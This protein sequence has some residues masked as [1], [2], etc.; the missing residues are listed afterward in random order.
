MTH[1][2]IIDDDAAACRS[3]ERH[4]SAARY[5]ITTARQDTDALA[6]ARISHPD[7]IIIDADL[8]DNRARDICKTLKRLERTREIPI[9][10]LSASRSL[11]VAEELFHAGASEYLSKPYTNDALER[12]VQL[13]LQSGDPGASG[14]LDIPA[15]LHEAFSSIAEQAA[16]LGDMAEV[17]HGITPRHRRFRRQAPLGYDWK[18]ILSASQVKRFVLNPPEVFYRFD[19]TGLLR[20][21]LPEEY[22]QPEK[23]VLCRTAP[24][25]V[26]AVDSSQH[27]VANDLYSIVPAKGLGC[28][29]LACLLNS[30]L[31]DF[32][33]NRI[34]PIQ[35]TPAGT[36]L[37]TVDI[38]AI[39]V[40]LPSAKT[41]AKFLMYAKAISGLG[42]KPQTGDKKT[43]RARFLNEMNQL[44]FDVYGLEPQAIRRLGDLHF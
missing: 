2:L 13:M 9:L 41:Q 14:Q 34:R 39:P 24:P 28:P 37:R 35:S 22:D 19:R 43:L 27:P 4:L 17:F 6:A 26:A 33:F 1:I 29:F 20:V 42:D 10:A 38:Q 36:Y 30:R 15:E 7:A 40:I 32:Y 23:V 11:T 44:I 12:K 5:K 31:I 8:K 18:G 3:I 25:L 21:P 16:Q